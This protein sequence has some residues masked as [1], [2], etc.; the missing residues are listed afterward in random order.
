MASTLLPGSVVAMTD[1][2]AQRLL[3]LD[4]G[5]AA[6]LYVTLLLKGNLDGVNWPESRLRPALESARR[7]A[8]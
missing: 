1:Q 4:N 2:A 5:D 6:L 7:N 8:R 3:K